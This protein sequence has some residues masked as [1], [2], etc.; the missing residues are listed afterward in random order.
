MIRHAGSRAYHAY[1][2]DVALNFHRHPI[3]LPRAGACGLYMP[4]GS[5]YRKF[6]SLYLKS[7]CS[8]YPFGKNLNPFSSFCALVFALSVKVTGFNTRNISFLNW[9]RFTFAGNLRDAFGKNRSCRYL[10]TRMLI[11][12]PLRGISSDD[13]MFSRKYTISDSPCIYK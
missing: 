6:D 7:H 11:S 5:A 10:I 1:N 9:L 13:Y 8:N 4:S 3:L 2:C 12:K